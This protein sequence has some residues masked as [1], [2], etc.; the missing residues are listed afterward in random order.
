MGRIA[1]LRSP[2]H[3]LGVASSL[4]VADSRN[5]FVGRSPSVC[6]WFVGP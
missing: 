1:A 4:Y 3:S 2:N 5:T 6:V